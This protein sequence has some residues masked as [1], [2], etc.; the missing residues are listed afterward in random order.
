[1]ANRD[2]KSRAQVT[3]AH[4]IVLQG[5]FADARQVTETEVARYRDELQGGASGLS[6][7]KDFAYALYVDA[8]ARPAGDSRRAA[9][10]AEASKQLNSLSAE[11]N[12]LLDIRELRGWIAA[13]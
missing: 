8:L 10:L 2:E 1:M 5:R 11:A 6:F 12:Q 13:A 9:N 4:A 7:T 3:L